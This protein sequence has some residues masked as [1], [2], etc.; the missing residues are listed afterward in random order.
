MA[1][2][3]IKP[4]IHGIGF[5]AEVLLAAG[6][7]LETRWQQLV[8]WEFKPNIT[9]LFREQ[10]LQPGNGFIINNSGITIL[11]VEN[12]DRHTPDP[13]AGNTPITAVSDHVVN[14]LFSQ[15]GIH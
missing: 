14:P 8:C 6:G 1:G 4:N 9:T 5:L 11:T 7:T 12:R 3:G 10:L 2:T 13:L 15:E